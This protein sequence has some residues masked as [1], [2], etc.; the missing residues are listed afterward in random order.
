MGQTWLFP[1]TT[2]LQG[3]ASELLAGQKKELE[4]GESLGRCSRNFHHMERHA[5]KCPLGGVPVIQDVPAVAGVGQPGKGWH[6]TAGAVPLVPPQPCCCPG[7][8]FAGTLRLWCCPGRE[9]CEPVL[10]VISSGE[11]LA[12]WPLCGDATA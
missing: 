7:R 8:C 10:F 1:G 6:G 2:G 5:A 4:L 11:K 3:T 12:G 9:L